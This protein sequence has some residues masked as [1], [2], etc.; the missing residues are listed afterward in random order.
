MGQLVMHR[1]GFTPQAMHAR[2][3]FF[4]LLGLFAGYQEERT[5]PGPQRRGSASTQVHT[6]VRCDA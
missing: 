2:I 5:V 3:L 1:A 4:C 6:R